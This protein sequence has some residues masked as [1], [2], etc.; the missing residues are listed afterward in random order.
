MKTKKQIML[1]KGEKEITQSRALMSCFEILI[2]VTSIIAFAYMIGSLDSD[3]SS[4]VNIEKEFNGKISDNNINNI[5]S[6]NKDKVNNFEKESKKSSQVLNFIFDKII[7]KIKQ[8]LLPMVSAVLPGYACCE[9][10]LNGA[11]CTDSPVEECESGDG[12]SVVP[13]LCSEV[14]Y[15]EEGCCVS[16]YGNCD[17]K[18]VEGDCNG[19]WKPS[20]MCNIEECRYGCCVLGNQVQWL[21]ENQCEVKTNELGL[22]SDFRSDVL[23]AES[24]LFLTQGELKGA[25]VIEIESIDSVRNCMYITAS[26][27]ATRQGDFNNGFCSNPE[28]NTTCTA[29]EYSGCVDG[30][31]EVY[32]FDSC[33][34]R[35]EVKKPCS[36]L[37]GTRCG[38]Y[39]PGIDDEP[40]DNSDYVCRDLSCNVEINGNLVNKKNG[41]SWCEYEGCIGDGKDPV[42]S[43]HVRHICSF[44]EEVIEECDDF[45]NGICVES[46]EDYSDGDD[47]TTAS[48]RVNQ[49]RS[50]YEYN[51]RD[52][53]SED[54]E[55]NPD[56][57]IKGVNIDEFKF[58]LCVPAYPPGF[59]FW[60]NN[61]LDP[62]DDDASR[63][64][65][66]E[67]GIATLECPVVYVKRICGHHTCWKCEMNC[68][69]E[70]NIFSQQMN[71]LCTSLGDCGGYINYNGDY[72][73]KGYISGAGRIPNNLIN[74]FEQCAEYQP[75]QNPAYP[76]DFGFNQ[77]LGMP[78]ELD[79]EGLPQPNT[80]MQMLGAGIGALNYLQGASAAASTTSGLFSNGVAVTV[81]NTGEFFTGAQA[82]DLA[83]TGAQGVYVP[84][85]PNP[86]TGIREVA[87]YPPGESVEFVTMPE[88]SATSEVGSKMGAE[89]VEGASKTPTPLGKALGAVGAA[90]S[91]ASFLQ[92][93]FGMDAGMSY[94]IGGVV[95]IYVY[96]NPVLAPYAIVLTILQFALGLGKTKI[97]YVQFT[98]SP[99]DAP[100]GGLNCDLCNIE[101]ELGVPC[102]EYR[103]KSL[104]ELCE[105]INPRTL[106]ELCV[107]NDPHDVGVPRISPL[108]SNISEGYEY[109]N[110]R[111]M[112][113]FEIKPLG[114]GC[115]AENTLLSFGIETDKPAQCRIGMNL[116]D[117][118]ESMEYFSGRSALLTEHLI[119]LPLIGP[120]E[121]NNRYA[122]SDSEIIELGKINYYVKC[123]SINGISNEVPFTIRTCVEPGTDIQAPGIS[124][125]EPATNSYLKYGE[126]EKQILFYINEPAD[127][128]WSLEDKEFEDM[129]NAA[130]CFNDRESYGLFGW[131]CQTTLNNITVDNY[132]FFFRCKDQP[133][134]VEEDL[135]NTMPSSTNYILRPSASPL[136]IDD[137]QPDEDEE[138]WSG[139]EPVDINLRVK[140]VGGADDTSKCS[141]K[142]NQYSDDFPEIN[143]IYHEYSVPLSRG[144]HQAVY[145]CQDKA[146]NTVENSTNFRIRI[147]SSGPKI[148]RIYYDSG[149]KVI[150]NE[151]SECRYSF[152]RFIWE[153]ATS[154]GGEGLEHTGEWQISRYTMQ[155]EDGY[156]NK[157]NKVVVRPY[158]L[159]N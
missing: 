74:E 33:G 20:A 30:K 13:E 42:G 48:C 31:D 18:T 84:I 119:T 77:I 129:E 103:C 54:C 97:K 75:D 4:N 111:E 91:V 25:C 101:D 57:T 98:C 28:L 88:S 40:A 5:E 104:G 117:E 1:G 115:A 135:R 154:M 21:N 155:C 131:P 56:C 12:F 109:I 8:P 158:T 76:G 89:T 50:C 114:G 14:D 85:G 58:D 72:T 61:N 78:E 94:A 112:E 159:V 140:T 83:N 47:F 150:T 92:A 68:D 120:A 157:G 32:W 63:S 95:G 124:K 146:G 2:L 38:V 17:A 121:F 35:E 102:S 46:S 19:E 64:G 99:W 136:T 87:Y 139:V 39:R 127:C 26:E 34:N 52:T 79:E 126:N 6:N 100:S 90:I 53:L 59:E 82:L 45:R 152:G 71:N 44:G 43:R 80:G 147:D 148:T 107:S 156:G 24:C 149:L 144:N 81:T 7:E 142:I 137:L 93:G 122:L 49:W 128:K 118:F 143:E 96:L 3:N 133:N 23:S 55:A 132:E 145:T 66:M 105:F 125:F 70:K 73:D 36:I 138:I 153:N 60:R 130:F 65:E 151:D 108:L 69:C 62:D 16:E 29:H 27:C 9:K 15:C 67:C 116:T 11:S 37:L 22:E 41:E 10:N 123:E 141:W 110:F 51:N 134:Q 86:V 106:D 113:S